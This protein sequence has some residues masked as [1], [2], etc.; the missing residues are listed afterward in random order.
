MVPEAN[1][2]VCDKSTCRLVTNDPNGIGTGRV[3][4]PDDTNCETMGVCGKTNVPNACMTPQ[5]AFNYYPGNQGSYVD[6]LTVP[7]GG[8]VK[9]GGDPTHFQ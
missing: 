2:F 9:E 3:Y 6:R 4:S 1:K 5:D 7:Y 8:Q